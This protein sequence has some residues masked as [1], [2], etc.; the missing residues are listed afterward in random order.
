MKQFLFALFL[1][2]ALSAQDVYT[3]SDG[4][5]TSRFRLAPD[6][7]A[8]RLLSYDSFAA[9]LN[10]ALP[11][12]VIQGQAGDRVLVRISPAADRRL[13]RDRSLALTQ[14][15]GVR[16]VAPILYDLESESSAARLARMT[17]EQRERRR[18]A[19]R[20]I[21]TTKVLVKAGTPEL[22]RIR[23]AYPPQSEQP[24]E[25]A[26]YYL[27]TYSTPWQALEAAR[28]M[29]EDSLI[30]ATPLLAKQQ[31]RK[32]QA[33]AAPA[34]GGTRERQITDPLFPLQWH[35]GSTGVNIGLNATWDFATGKGINVAVVDDG[36]ELN[37]PDLRDNVYPLSSDYHAN[38]NGGDLGGKNPNPIDPDDSHGTACAGII[39][40]VMNNIG[41][42][43]IAPDAKLMALRLI[44]GPATDEDEAKAFAWQP[45]GLVTH[46]SSNS[47]GPD[48]DGATLG[49]PGPLTAAAIE[50]AAM[51]HRDGK[52]TVIVVAA[53]N[54]SGDGDISSYDGY[55][56]NRHVIGV[57]AV[58]A[59]GAPSSYSEWGVNVALTALGG[60]FEPPAA[61]VTTNLTG[62][63]ANQLI[64][65]KKNSKAPED[66]M[67][68]FNGTSAATPM[69]SAAAA[70]LL[71]KYP[72]LSARDVKE[73]LMRSATR[74]G[75]IDGDEFARNGGGLHFSHS[76]GAG[77]LNVAGAMALAHDWTNLGPARS[78]EEY[79]LDGEE[80]IEEGGPGLSIPIEVAEVMRVE[81]V[82]LTV[83]VKHANRGDITF[84]LISPSGMRSVIPGRT[85]DENADFENWTFTSVRHWGEN[86]KGIWTIRILDAEE[87]EIEGVVA[88]VSLQF[89]GS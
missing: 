77:L 35:I 10:K 62:S 67:D 84:A 2:A 56:G 79:I 86:S 19:A 20:R 69:V 30:T 51:K 17:P 72:D 1:T 25:A 41:V 38:F 73:I 59:D 3:F 14:S 4:I 13:V 46:V 54:G 22:D 70:L 85:P 89:H 48:D 6:E 64:T 47:W 45:D 28:G 74:T 50:K 49:K 55:S 87:N 42:A 88:K 21:V 76:F 16:E 78:S 32:W 9:E 60:E 53:G 65:E 27:L 12:A 68:V 26:G 37:H 5:S 34:Y 63:A 44:D 36:V 57:G 33:P 58:N 15:S 52:G 40:A 81:T 31:F 29:S 66:Y 71:S 75:L 83:S 11:R 8:V 39:A 24:A 7:F 18:S 61:I 82:Q 43:G 23:A 80:P